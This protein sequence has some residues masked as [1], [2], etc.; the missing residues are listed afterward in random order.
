MA[1]CHHGNSIDITFGN[2]AQAVPTN[3]ARVSVSA[4]PEECHTV[5]L[6]HMPVYR[7]GPIATF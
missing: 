4:P 5:G 1:K 2:Q 7:E 3:G 6:C